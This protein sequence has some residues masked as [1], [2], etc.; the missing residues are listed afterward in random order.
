MRVGLPDEQT[1]G[2]RAWGRV[3][4]LWWVL[5]GGL[6]L[7]ASGNDGRTSDTFALSAS[8]AGV[9]TNVAQVLTMRRAH[10]AESPQVRLRGLVT[11]Y[12]PD[13]QLFFVQDLTGGIYLYSDRKHP[14]LHSGQ[15][16]ELDGTAHQGRLSPVVWEEN[17]RRLKASEI[18]AIIPRPR[19][20]STGSLQDTNADSQWVEINA[21]VR[22]VRSDAGQL[23]VEFG[24]ASKRVSFSVP[25]SPGFTN[26]VNLPRSRV[27]VRGVCTFEHR[28]LSL[29]PLC[30]AASAS[31]FEVIAPGARDPF[32][33]PTCSISTVL[34]AAPTSEDETF[35][36][37][38]GVITYQK[39]AD[40]WYL[41]GGTS[42]LAVRVVAQ[43]RVRIGDQVEVAGF[44][45]LTE[46]PPCV[47]DAVVRCLGVGAPVVPTLVNP[48]ADRIGELNGRLVSVEGRMLQYSRRPDQDLLTVLIAGSL[49]KAELEDTNGVRQLAN[50]IPESWL[51]LTGVWVE[52]DLA[53]AASN[54]RL[55]LRSAADVTVLRVPSW[56]TASHFLMV[57]GGLGA[58]CSLGLVWVISL[59]R[60]VRRQTEQ[61]RSRLA[62]E[63]ELEQRYRDL[64]EE[65]NDAIWTVDRGGRF[66]SVNRAGERMLGYV[67]QELIG[68]RITD[69]ATAEARTAFENLLNG[70]FDDNHGRIH[71]VTVSAKD[72]TQRILEVSTK[73][74]TPGR[75][76]EELLA[77]ARDVTER[78]KAAAEL[79][80]LHQELVETS[81][82]AGMAEV[83]TSVLHNVGNVLNSVNVS[84]ALSIDRLRQ[85]KLGRLTQVTD[86]LIQKDNAL[87]DFLTRDARGK[88]IPGYLSA[89]VP[90][91][92]EEQTYVL[93]EL[94]SLRDKIDHI[95]EIV[96][97]QQN[98]ARVSGAT[99]I[100]PVTVLVEDALKLNLGALTRHQ[101]HVEREFEDFR[102]RNWK[103]TRS[104]K[105]CSTLS[106]T[107]NMPWTMAA[108][109]QR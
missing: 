21:I 25:W 69:L 60:Q 6:I 56:W 107:P 64:I 90:V 100:L 78:H 75:R 51:R 9:L 44:I 17:V 54:P 97:M 73:P 43:P 101:I 2:L 11:L 87:G 23:V 18:P 3:L 89:L 58:T 72:A 81:H 14:D 16:I 37:V 82:Q 99:E 13:W 80:K 30:F 7:L 55:L 108:V 96:S 33:A 38:R 91:L 63:A 94:Y 93:D 86:L 71:E 20:V 46:Q 50:L 26:M 19:Q 66:L 62:K 36:H 40:N 15:W 49:L 57:V 59:R 12:Q 74:F 102:P 61:I 41:Q 28:G 98:Y 104:C 77:I 27:R 31:D 65:A 95:K 53:H 84:C 32:E 8:S 1:C 4:H 68:R 47:E 45:S 67:R 76:S 52:S 39:D 79:V 109:N 34:Q 5:L 22:S 10:A 103:G 48:V 92:V 85:S 29:R 24:P 105:S 42:A 70:G 88:Q 83:A 35:V 106:E